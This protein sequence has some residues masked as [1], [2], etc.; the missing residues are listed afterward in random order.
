MQCGAPGCS[1]RT[2][3]GTLCLEIKARKSPLQPRDPATDAFTQRVTASGEEPMWWRSPRLVL[4]KAMQDMCVRE[5][6][7]SVLGKDYIMHLTARER[8]DGQGVMLT[9]DSRNLCKVV[10]DMDCDGQPLVL[11][12]SCVSAGGRA[13]AC[14][15]GRRQTEGE[16]YT[17]HGCS[18]WY[19]AFMSL[20]EREAYGRGCVPERKEVQERVR[21]EKL[22]EFLEKHYPAARKLEK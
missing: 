1:R 3:I 4:L 5:L 20:V 22:S 13:R 11:V 17:L 12:S 8:E 2:T 18:E 6:S 15:F 10:Q 19:A 16:L 7:V 14:V 21:E 9:F